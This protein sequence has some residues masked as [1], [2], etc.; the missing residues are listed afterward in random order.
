M[1]FEQL[2]QTVNEICQ[3][4][5]D[6]YEKAQTD[7]QAYADERGLLNAI[8]WRTDELARAFGMF[9]EAHAWRMDTATGE[10]FDANY[11]L[12]RINE[13]RRCE[14]RINESTN[15]VNNVIEDYKQMGWQKFRLGYDAPLR[16]IEKA[17]IAYMEATQ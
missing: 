3:E 14:W 15:R 1:T 17:A 2:Q 9:Q 12:K 5:I 6:A 7:F 8:Q 16:Q 10:T 13:A 4:A 11:F